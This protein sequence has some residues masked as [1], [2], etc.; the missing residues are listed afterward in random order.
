MRVIFASLILAFVLAG[1]KCS[2]PGARKAFNDQLKNIV[3]QAEQLDKARAINA[4]ATRKVKIDSLLNQVARHSCFQKRMRKHNVEFA[5]LRLSAKLY[6]QMWQRSD[7]ISVR[8]ENREV[9]IKKIKHS[10]DSM[11]REIAALQHSLTQLSSTSGALQYTSELIK[12]GSDLARAQSELLSL[13]TNLIEPT[14]NQAI[15]R[16]EQRLLQS[17]VFAARQVFLKDLLA[18]KLKLKIR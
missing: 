12:T 3:S 2:K 14:L 15:Q 11:K 1:C 13:E 5:H 16:G 10:V 18:L 4:S 6:D 9:R 8:L 17:D 7:S